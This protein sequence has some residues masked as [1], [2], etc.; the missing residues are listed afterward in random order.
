MNI[1]C[2]ERCEGEKQ[3]VGRCDGGQIQDWSPSPFFK[4][5]SALNKAHRVS[6][7]L[8]SENK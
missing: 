2:L 3:V 8:G 6:F 4:G 5:W 1:G 7:I